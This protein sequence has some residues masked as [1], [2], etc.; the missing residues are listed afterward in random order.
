M[1]RGI[2]QSERIIDGALQVMP[3]QPCAIHLAEDMARGLLTF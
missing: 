3:P 1:E 2:L